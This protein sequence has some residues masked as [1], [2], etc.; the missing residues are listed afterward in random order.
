M[1]VL[2][3]IIVLVVMYI[4]IPAAIIGGALIALGPRGP[5]RR[6]RTDTAGYP[7]RRP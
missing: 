6:G 7:D 2:W 4:V 3:G 1:D 5:R